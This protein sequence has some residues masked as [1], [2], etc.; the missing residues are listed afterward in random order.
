MKK[1]KGVELGSLFGGDAIEVWADR[2]ARKDVLRDLV[3]EGHPLLEAEMLLLSAA[4]D[5]LRDDA[6][7]LLRDRGF[8]GPVERRLLSMAARY[9][10][11]YGVSPDAIRARVTRIRDEDLPRILCRPPE[12][13]RDILPRVSA[14]VGA[15]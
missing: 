13:L 2:V 10:R 14:A 6:G 11:A 8:A 7:S 5:T 3:P 1:I 15:A 4:E 12:L 9:L